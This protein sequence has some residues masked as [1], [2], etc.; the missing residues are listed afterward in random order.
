M[1]VQGIVPDITTISSQVSS[2]EA[3][4]STKI[5]GRGKRRQ[6]RV[7]YKATSDSDDNKDISSGKLKENTENKLFNSNF[8]F[9]V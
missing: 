1:D 5:L 4:K 2:D 9:N 7:I 3:S 8:Y 6:K